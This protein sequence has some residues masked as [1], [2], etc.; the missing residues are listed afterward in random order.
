MIK[1]ESRWGMYASNLSNVIIYILLIHEN[2]SMAWSSIK[3]SLSPMTCLKT[4]TTMQWRSTWSDPIRS[5]M[6]LTN[7][8]KKRKMKKEIKHMKNTMVTKNHYLT[9]FIKYI[10]REKAW[11]LWQRKKNIKGPL[12]PIKTL[13][14]LRYW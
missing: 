9:R 4:C 10:S 13:D 5:I 8:S 7:P 14:I 11:Q 12:T 2:S 3:G 6:L 1:G